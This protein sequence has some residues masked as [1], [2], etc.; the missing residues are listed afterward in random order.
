VGAGVD[1]GVAAA[2]GALAVGGGALAGGGGL[3]AQ[4]TTPIR[5]NQQGRFIP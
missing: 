5:T 1:A 3:D 4:P 2:G